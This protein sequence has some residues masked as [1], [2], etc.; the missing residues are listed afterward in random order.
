MAMNRCLA[1]LGI[2]IALAQPCRDVAANEA[3]STPG[4]TDAT[5]IEQQLDASPLVELL[6]LTDAVGARVGGHGQQWTMVSRIAAWRVHEGATRHDTLYLRR[7]GAKPELDELASQL[8]AYRIARLR[9]RLSE[10]NV[11]HRPTALL[12][13]IIDGQ[14]LDS[15]LRA[16][17][18]KLQEPAERQVQGLGRFALDRSIDLLS[19]RLRWR[20]RFVEIHV[21]QA[22]ETGTELAFDVARELLVRQ[23]HWQTLLD[24]HL[25]AA[26]LPIYN[27]IWRNGNEPRL[28]DQSFLRTV[29][30]TSITVFGDGRFEFWYSDGDLFGGHAIQ[31]RGSM[32]RGIVESGLSG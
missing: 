1:R 29:Q 11:H 26:M 18:V 28:S 9:V 16:I 7:Q 5:T 8:P 17:A 14:L 31:V 13:D 23:V 15:E 25:V 24:A 3:P 22:S 4:T 27:D 21:P 20:G 32:S 2:M 12:V 19:G 10:E 6:V 30:L